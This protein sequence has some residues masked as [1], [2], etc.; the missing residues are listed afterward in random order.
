MIQ[1]GFS[2]V[3]PAFFNT[4]MMVALVALASD[5]VPNIRFNAAKTMEVVK[6]QMTA[7]NKEK[8]SAI[9]EDLVK[10]DTDQ[11]V[12]FYASKCLAAL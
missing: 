4:N 3:R 5:P 2:E 6:D 8:A 11:D 10:L 7:E 12:K 9:M 1:H